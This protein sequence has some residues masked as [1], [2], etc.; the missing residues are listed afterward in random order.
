MPKVILLV[1]LY[2]HQGVLYSNDANNGVL[3]KTGK[4]P[5]V[6]DKRI[7]FVRAGRQKSELRFRCTVYQ[8]STITTPGN[9]FLN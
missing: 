6:R 5:Y 4:V 8:K 3:T 9:E 2:H 1:G 7:G